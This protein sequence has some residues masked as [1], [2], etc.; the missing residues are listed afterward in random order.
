MSTLYGMVIDARSGG[1]SNRRLVALLGGGL[2]VLLASVVGGV[3]VWRADGGSTRPDVAWRLPD[4]AGSAAFVADGN[5]YVH[6]G[7]RL[8]AVDPLTGARRWRYPAA[9]AVY[10]RLP[11]VA[12]GRVYAVEERAGRL[13]ALDSTT[14][15]VRW[16]YDGGYRRLAHP[17]EAGGGAY[18]L[19]AEA[20]LTA[21]DAATGAVRWRYPTGLAPTAPD[22]TRG[23]PP[24]PSDDT[25]YVI[26]PDGRLVAVEAASGAVRWEVPGL[27]RRWGSVVVA[28]RLAFA[29]NDVRVTA[30]D[31]ATGRQLWSRQPPGNWFSGECLTVRADTTYLLGADRLEAVDTRTGAP[32]WTATIPAARFATV[33]DGRT[34]HP[35]NQLVL[36][37]DAIYVAPQSLVALDAATGQRRW[38]VDTNLGAAPPV[39]AGGT[40]Y[41]AVSGADDTPPNLLTLDARTGERKARWV[42]D[43]TS[44][45][46]VPNGNDVLDAAPGVV[47]YDCFGC[48]EAGTY[49]IRTGR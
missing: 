48:V 43:Q 35:C 49:G 31:P 41:L 42:P 22:T 27:G 46:W 20:N 29:V 1:R 25:V 38:T 23:M 21:L 36:A 39:L 15:A 30:L 12:N 10:A 18:L 8:D 19:D 40:L 7:N 17:V 28:E 3:A 34:V 32:R 2:V 6:G 4:S 5:L 24:L 45:K 26:A 33:A 13:S 47:V 44:K 11:G 9:T 16:H 37:G 14:G